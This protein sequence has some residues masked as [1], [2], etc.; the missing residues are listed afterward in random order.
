MKLI[1][2][3]NRKYFVHRYRWSHEDR[4]K[5]FRRALKDGKVKILLKNRDGWLYQVNN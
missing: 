5:L 4:R 1:L 2:E 3:P